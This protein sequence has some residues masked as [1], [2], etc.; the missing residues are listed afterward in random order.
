MGKPSVPC[1][2]PGG[3]HNPKDVQMAHWGLGLTRAVQLTGWW[4][5]QVRDPPIDLPPVAIRRSLTKV[6]GTQNSSLRAHYA[7]GAKPPRILA[8]RVAQ[9]DLWLAGEYKTHCDEHGASNA[10]AVPVRWTMG[11]VDNAEVSAL[12]KGDAGSHRTCGT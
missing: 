10:K 5:A 4:A 1:P 9:A 6:M 2:F 3:T 8:V 7:D 12:Q 11:G